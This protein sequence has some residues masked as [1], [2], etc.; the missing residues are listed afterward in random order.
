VQEF[1]GLVSKGSTA[2]LALLLLY[3]KSVFP[4][5]FPVQNA[6]YWQ[7]INNKKYAFQPLPQMKPF[8]ASIFK[9]LRT[10]FVKTRSFDSLFFYRSLKNDRPV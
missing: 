6:S 8:Q 5:F 10:I 3:K 9:F 1:N 4:R 2:M 7:K